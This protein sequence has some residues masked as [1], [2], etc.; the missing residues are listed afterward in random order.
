M[1]TSVSCLPT[2]THSAPPTPLLSLIFRLLART[3]PSK[4]VSEKVGSGYVGLLA[5]VAVLGADCQ[6]GRAGASG[7]TPT[8]RRSSRSNWYSQSLSDLSMCSSLATC[9]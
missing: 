7:V 2:W 3:R 5:L 8:N 9:D 1:V 6:E 4:A